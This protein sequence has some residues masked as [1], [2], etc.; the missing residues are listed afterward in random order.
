VRAHRVSVSEH[1]LEGVL[2]VDRE[3][4]RDVEQLVDDLLQRTKAPVTQ[5][6]AGAA[7]GRICRDVASTQV[8]YSGRSLKARLRTANKLGVRWVVLANSDEA[9]RRLA[10][11]KE[12]ATGEQHEVP[13]KDLPDRLASPTR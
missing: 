2:E 11:L 7:L 4:A 1:S 8:D 5:A 10:Q 6:L 13:W 9:A 3:A 12:M